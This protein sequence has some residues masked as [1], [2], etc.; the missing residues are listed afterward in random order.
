MGDMPA[1]YPAY[2]ASV[3]MPSVKPWEWDEHADWMNRVLAIHGIEDEAYEARRAK[4]RNDEAPP[5]EAPTTGGGSF[6]SGSLNPM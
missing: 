4:A 3:C 2:R 1:W 6:S 5:D